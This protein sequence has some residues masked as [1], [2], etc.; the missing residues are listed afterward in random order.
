VRVDYTKGD[1]R[2]VAER[3]LPAARRLVERCA[4]EA[5]QLVVDVAAGSGNV[6]RLCRARGAHAVAVDLEVEQLRLGREAGDAIGWVVGD[7]GALPLRDGVASQVLSTFGLIFA[8]DPSRAVEQAA[9][10]CRSG[11]VL[12][13]ATW[14]DQHLQRAQ[15]DVMSSVLPDLRGGH[16]PLATWGSETAVVERLRPVADDVTVER[17]LLTR[18]YASV[19]AWWEDRSRTAPPVVTA[20]QHLSDEEFAELGERLRSAVRPFARPVDGGLE[21][22]DAYLLTVARVR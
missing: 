15:Y 2:T 16:D 10:V 7:A 22:D 8:T 17:G 21:L 14:S 1:Y 11:G 20:R 3:L 12:G 4:P 18:T 9:R 6:A 5:G 13:L 19:D